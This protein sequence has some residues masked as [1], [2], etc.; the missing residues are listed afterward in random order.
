MVEH[1]IKK[2]Q[3]K[4]AVAKNPISFREGFRSLLDTLASNDIPT[5]IFSAGLAGILF[6]LPRLYLTVLKPD[7]IH[8]VLLNVYGAAI[9][10]SNLHVISNLMQFNSQGVLTGFVGKVSS[11]R[12]SCFNQVI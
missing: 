2:E 9:M 5:L 4:E 6:Y 8:E 12:M 3:I 1:D 11:T 7:I 10:T